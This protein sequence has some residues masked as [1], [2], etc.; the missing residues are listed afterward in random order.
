MSSIGR[1][2]RSFSGGYSDSR[3]S[4]GRT[5]VQAPVWTAPAA[6]G[7][8]VA[9]DAVGEVS[10]GKAVTKVLS[11]AGSFDA[12]SKRLGQVVMP[13]ED[14]L[15]ARQVVSFHRGKMASSSAGGVVSA[16][17]WRRWRAHAAP[18]RNIGRAPAPCPLP[19]QCSYVSSSPPTQAVPAGEAA[20]LMSLCLLWWAS[21]PMRRPRTV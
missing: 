20:G 2:R 1:K 6:Y 7:A 9:L 18:L 16:S 4:S 8:L 14:R 11:H 17:C 13:D 19:V 5:G 3:W 21:G 15:L 10:L 12:W